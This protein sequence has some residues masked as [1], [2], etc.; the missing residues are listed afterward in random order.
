MNLSL[1]GIR[2]IIAALILIESRIQGLGDERGT[3]TKVP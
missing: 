1:N 3:L 2:S